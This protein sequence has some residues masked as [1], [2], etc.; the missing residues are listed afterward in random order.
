MKCTI[1]N[2]GELLPINL[3]KSLSCLQCDHCE[4][5]WIKLSHY[6]EWQAIQEPS[7]AVVEDIGVEVDVAESKL[8]LTCPETRGI[9]T[10]FRIMSNI[11]H[12][13]D[14]ST[15]AGA[16]WLDKGEWEL[17]VAKGI[18]DKMNRIFTD[19]WQ[20]KIRV[21]TRR[22]SKESRYKKQFG[23]NNYSRLKLVRSWLHEQKD[24][25]KTMMVAFLLASD[26]FK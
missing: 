2:V 26:P 24:E 11:P 20:K 15:S 7:S 12:R 10:K 14:L 19:Q 5:N 16:I 21:E 9:M 1:C 4:G 18:A 23:E 22:Y 25:D 13:I 8:A 3:K 17:L 6:L